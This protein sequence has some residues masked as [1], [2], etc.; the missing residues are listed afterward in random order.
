LVLPK[1]KNQS[2][3]ASLFFLE[4]ATT[5]AT[6][7]PVQRL[8]GIHF[9]PRTTTRAFFTPPAFARPTDGTTRSPRW[10]RV[11]VRVQERI[12]Q[13]LVLAA[14]RTGKERDVQ[15]AMAQVRVLVFEIGSTTPFLTE[16]YQDLRIVITDRVVNG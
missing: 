6:P 16:K 11:N 8:K 1:K 3:V 9:S 13:S 15:T 2:V 10:H 4:E 5:T 14:C 12:G 7:S